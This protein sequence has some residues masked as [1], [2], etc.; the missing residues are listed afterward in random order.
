VSGPR[1]SSGPVPPRRVAFARRLLAHQKLRSGVAA[2]GI[3]FSLLVIFLQLGFYRAVVRSATAISSRLDAD[4]VLVSPRFVHLAE[5][6]TIDRARLFQAQGLPEVASARPLYL[7]HARWRDPVSG[8]RCKFLA[9][10]FPLDAGAPLALP[11]LAARISALAP[12]DALL[13][14]EESQRSCGPRDPEGRVEL[15]EQAARVAGRFRL[16]VGFQADGA[17]LLSD[18][19][20]S[21]YFGASPL[22]RPQLGLIRLEPGSDAREA[23]LRLR[24]L[25]PPDVEVRTRAELRELQIRHW[26]RNTAV[27]NVFALGALAGFAVGLVVLHQVLATDLRNQLP[28]YATLAAMGYAERRLRGF[29]LGQAGLLV[30]LA[31]G[32]ALGGA[33]ALFALVARAT[34][35]P[36]A[37]SPGLALGVAALAAA[38]AAAAALFAVRRLRRADPAE[39]S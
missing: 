8:E 35:L 29:V 15:R 1:E 11:E 37:L 3:A 31:F 13:L 33:L 20:F 19:S 23:A 16:G 4:L 30:A 5:A 18:A 25:L 24:A 22:E 6:D 17:L 12:S 2:A 28:H 39:L 7:R 26:V 36:I 32:P 27:G 14:D 10:G 34:R 9:L 38:M 21:R